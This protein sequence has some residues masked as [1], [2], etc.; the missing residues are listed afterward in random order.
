MRRSRDNDRTTG[1]GGLDGIGICPF[2]A[3]MRTCTIEVLDIL[4]DLTAQMILT[5][6]QDMIQQFTPDT[7]NEAFADR[8]G[9]G[10]L[11]WRVDHIDPGPFGN[12]FELSVSRPAW[13]AGAQHAAPLIPVDTLK[14]IESAYSRKDEL[15]WITGRCRP[16]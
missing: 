5:Q 10:C 8:I 9:F 15:S 3:L 12:A 11:D 4:L 13:L 14:I 16:R 7:A 6:N 2:D 1:G